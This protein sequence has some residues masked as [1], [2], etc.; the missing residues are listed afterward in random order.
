MTLLPNLCL[1]TGRE[2]RGGNHSNTVGMEST[3]DQTMWLFFKKKKTK[4]KKLCLPGRLKVCLLILSHTVFVY[5]GFL[6]LISK[7]R[8]VFNGHKL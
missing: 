3:W 1:A 6:F 4:N 8:D 5:F 7:E 2:R